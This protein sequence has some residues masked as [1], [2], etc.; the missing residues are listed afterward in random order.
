M[1][2]MSVIIADFNSQFHVKDTTNAHFLA[3]EIFDCDDCDD[4][5]ARIYANTPVAIGY[6]RM[7]PIYFSVDTRSALM[8]RR[9]RRP[10]IVPDPVYLIIWL[11]AGVA[12][13]MGG[14]LLKGDY[15]L[16]PGNMVAGAIGGIVSTLILHALIPALRAID[17]GPIIGHVI[18]AAASGAVLTVI[19]GAVQIRWR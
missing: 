4:G 19:V 2:A 1:I 13:G 15:D 7:G 9:A 16:G 3:N 5:T 18:V 12:G 8:Q 10:D 6:N 17:F 11:I 14:E